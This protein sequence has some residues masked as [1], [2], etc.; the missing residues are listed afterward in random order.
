MRP[1]PVYRVLLFYNVLGRYPFLLAV[2]IILVALGTAMPVLLSTLGT[3]IFSGGVT[4][5]KLA[6]SFL[7]LWGCAGAGTALGSLL[8]PRVI[9]D[10]RLSVFLTVIAVLRPALRKYAVA[11]WFCTE[12]I[13]TH[14]FFQSCII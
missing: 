12:K 2:Q 4:L 6:Q 13:L 8:S 11:G 7:L 14:C 5:G 9:R 3:G 1:D 10:R